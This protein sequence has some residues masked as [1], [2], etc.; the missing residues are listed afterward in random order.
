[1]IWPGARLL[2]VMAL[3]AVP[4][5][6]LAGALPGLTLPCAV[7]GCIVLA[8]VVMD[9]MRLIRQAQTWRVTGD[10]EL[11][12]FQGRTGVIPL[13]LA[14]ESKRPTELLIYL[15]LL[16]ALGAAEPVL[17]ARLSEKGTVEVVCTPQQ[18][19][20]YQIT[21]CFLSGQSPFKL[22]HNRVEQAIHIEIRVYPD[23]QRDST[24][25]ML[26]LRRSAGVRRLRLVGRGRDFER[27]RDYAPGDSF[28]EIYWKATARRGAPIVKVFQVE[29]TQDIYVILDSSRL[30]ARNNALEQFISAALTVALATENEGD[31]FGL[32]TFSSRVDRF[33]RAGRGKAHFARCRDALYDLNSS[34]VS[35][36]FEDLFANLQLQ[37]RRRS[38]LLFLTD[39]SDPMLSEVFLRDAPSLARKHVLL[40][41]EWSD[42][43]SRPLFSG[44]APANLEEI[45][46]RLAGHLQW[47]KRQDLQHSLRQK[48]IALHELKLGSASADLV[49][50]YLQ[51]K[52]KQ[53]L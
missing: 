17:K 27:L 47:A 31:H 48:G 5:C 51:V 12:W 40:V 2:W 16:P 42:E 33:I 20:H 18:R 15:D 30:S 6:A 49:R 8:I 43:E 41:N 32:V 23:L 3:A 50:Q 19:G 10:P 4:L 29:R 11:Q 52:Q 53:V 45:S 24:A 35:P 7:A 13:A 34:A 37:V 1:M 9:A 21:R 22:W 46:E 26:L 39:L 38:L 28:D 25:R 36:D 44:A 14:S